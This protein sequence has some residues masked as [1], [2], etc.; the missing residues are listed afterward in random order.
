M[1]YQLPINPTN[2]SLLGYSN[3]QPFDPRSFLDTFSTTPVSPVT[4]TPVTGS[5]SSSSMATDLA[6]LSTPTIE[7]TP[8]PLATAAQA[9]A[10]V[11]GTAQAGQPG[12]AGLLR[13]ANGNLNLGNME[14]LTG[15]VGTLGTLYGAWQQHKLAK[16]SFNFQKEAYEKNMANQTKS[17]NTALEDRIRSRNSFTGADDSKSDDYLKKHSL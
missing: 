16:E 5:Y 8:Q 9:N 3:T 15:I 12:R 7:A 2:T 14:T 4:P 10:A 1:A 11:P 13:D 17:Y 6:N